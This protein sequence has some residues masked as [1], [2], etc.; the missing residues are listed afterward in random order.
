M[1]MTKGMIVISFGTSYKDTCEK[2]I[3]AIEKDLRAAFPE[4]KFYRAWTSSFIRKKIF[5]RDG[6]KILS[7]E[8]ALDAAKEE[9]I[10]DVLI[11]PTH[12]LAGGEFAKIVDALRPQMERFEKVAVGRPLLETE[13]DIK[14]F[15]KIMTDLFSDVREDEMAVF[16][17]HG[18]GSV[19]L[20][21]YPL[22]NDGFAREGCEN[23]CV[24]TVE[25]EPGIE[26]VLEKVRERKPKK[27]YLS[28]LLI[29]AGDHANNDMA[30]DGPDSWKNLIAAEG[31]EVE[32]IV[33][34][35]GEYPEI[36][37]MYAE[38]AKEAEK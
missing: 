3:G 23:F 6:E 18:S 10:T 5:E 29:V 35:L 32:C 19:R 4:R 11:L 14:K 28:P 13:A 25:Y 37:A 24:G 22:L 30:G 16:M 15:V 33:K 38:R 26:P 8:E 2:T 9:G 12:M 7:P 36:R 21:V 1:S 31:T 20:P 27:V 34:G 17:G